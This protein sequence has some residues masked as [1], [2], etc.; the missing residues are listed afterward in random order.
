MFNR[1]VYTRI[2]LTGYV[3]TGGR[4][5]TPVRP[6]G[7]CAARG[8]PASIMCLKKLYLFVAISVCSG[9]YIVD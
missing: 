3:L 5:A 6:G 8:E 2:G 4:T 7:N 9:G 1:L